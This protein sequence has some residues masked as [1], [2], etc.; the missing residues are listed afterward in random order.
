M[1]NLNLSY[2]RK[3]TCDHAPIVSTHN[4]WINWRINSRNHMI[5]HLEFDWLHLYYIILDLKTFSA[6]LILYLPNSWKHVNSF[7]FFQL[8]CAISDTIFDLWKTVSIWY[9]NKHPKTIVMAPFKCQIC[10]GTI[11]PCE[12]SREHWC[13]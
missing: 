10:N 7:N 5:I 3:P 9:R 12:M 13:K 2:C 4:P 8:S 11:D 1:E 6:N